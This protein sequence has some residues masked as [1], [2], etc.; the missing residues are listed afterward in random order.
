MNK[1]LL[2]LIAFISTFIVWFIISYFIAYI[3]AKKRDVHV[4]KYVLRVISVTIVI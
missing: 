1:I 3:I 4:G 2:V